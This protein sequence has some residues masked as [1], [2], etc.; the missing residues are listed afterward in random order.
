MAS[1]SMFGFFGTVCSTR[2]FQICL[3]LNDDKCKN[4]GQ[5]ACPGMSSKLQKPPRT[6]DISFPQLLSLM[7]ETFGKP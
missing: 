5:V 2:R 1:L 3:D 4:V 6:V 7:M